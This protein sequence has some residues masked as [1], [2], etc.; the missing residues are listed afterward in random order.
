MNNTKSAAE[1]I[2]SGTLR[3]DREAPKHTPEVGYTFPECPKHLKGEARRIWSQVKREMTKYTLI[4]GADMPI[5][6]QYC[7][8][9]TK[10]RAAPEDFSA[11]LHGQLRGV[12][13][14]LY[15]TPESRT[16]LKLEAPDP[17]GDLRKKYG[18]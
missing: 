16:K 17:D 13:S 2:L 7:Y 1:K 4:T 5:L 6:E 8:L 9:L 14:D 18:V 11:S 10:L 15:L 3:K 12:A